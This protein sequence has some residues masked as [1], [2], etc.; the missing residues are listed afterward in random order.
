[1]QPIRIIV[2][3]RSEYAAGDAFEIFGDGGV[4]DFD[5]SLT[6]RPVRLWPEA[7]LGAGFLL[8]GHL[9]G[10]HLEGVFPDGHLE[11]AHLRDTH[12]VPEL[13]VVW[14]SRPY[15]FGRFQHVLKM[16]DA[17]GNRSDDPSPT[18]VHTIN[19]APRPPRR[20]EKLGYDEDSDQAVF[21]I[22][23]S[24]PLAE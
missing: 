17:V 9:L 5:Q 13:A 15:V 24:P 12:L 3:R 7:P 23:A 1:M 21:S 16:V 14:E 6:P 11:G 4:V 19:S 2:T 20:F 18:F 22:A 10:V 8:D